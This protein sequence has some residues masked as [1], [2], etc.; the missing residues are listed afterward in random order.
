MTDRVLHPFARVL[1]VA[2]LAV[3]I[4]ASPD[5][6]SAQS[7]SPDAPSAQP[8]ENAPAPP[9]PAPERPRRQLDDPINER[10]KYLH[11]RLRITPGQEP[12]WA[13]VAAVMRENGKTVAPLIRERLRSAQ[14]GTAV[15]SLDAYEQLGEAQLDDLKKFIAAFRALYDSFSAEQRKIADSIFR[16]GPLSMIGGIPEPPEA[17]MAPG[18]E[19][20]PSPSASYAGLP[21][22]PYPGYAYVPPFPYYGYTGPYYA[23]SLWG[24]PLALGASPFFFHRPFFHHHFFHGA[25]VHGVHGVHDGFHHR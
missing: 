10:I 14:H 21:P 17:L 13:K 1:A 15:E 16:I 3:V 9:P 12:L 19:E 6:R 5:G 8:P 24:A 4:G 18:P 23:P 11:E 7:P 20:Y 22:T 25:S 2:V